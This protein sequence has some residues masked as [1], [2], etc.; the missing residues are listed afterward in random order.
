MK[1][2]SERQAHCPKWPPP[3]SITAV[4]RLGPVLFAVLVAGLVGSACDLTPPAASV[5][6]ST[7]TT[8]ALDT[9]LQA[10][11]S[12]QAGQCLLEA[13]TGGA[14]QTRGSGGSG[15]YD[16]GFADAIL[17]NAVT[18]KLAAQLAASKG[19]TITPADLS[20]ATT[21]FSA[22]LGG[23]IGAATQQSQQSGAPSYCVSSQGQ[24]LTASQVLGAIPPSQRASLVRNNAVDNRLL[25]DGAN[26]AAAQIKAFYQ[27]H[28]AQFTTTCVS[29]IL[30]S[31]QADATTY[32]AEINAGAPFAS[33]A[34]AHSLDTSSAAAGGALG[35]S[36]A[37]STVEQALGVTTITPG[38][39][40]G[41]IR[42]GSNGGYAI[43]EATSEAL[44]PL[45]RASA[46]IHQ[47]LLQSRSNG[48]RVSSE[49]VAYA[50]RSKVSIDP[51]YGTWKVHVLIPPKAPPASTLLASAFGTPQRTSQPTT[52]TP[53]TSPGG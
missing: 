9:Q 17:Q 45:S 20:T 16:M 53:T 18:N 4:K 38:K 10:L 26:I 43:Y 23:E 50:H 24:A 22:L 51:Q 41:P 42:S 11:D 32:L 40:F 39:P 7:I 35:C 12:G 25:S 34:K 31:T 30:A 19:L 1:V 48:N 2:A 44:L 21:D 13:Q 8:G 15:T 46:D 28:P 37:L 14:I 29:L 33:V 47:E 6:G 36:F 52:S 3:G 5:N 27:S 49:I